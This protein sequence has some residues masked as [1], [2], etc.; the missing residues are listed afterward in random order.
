M[1]PHTP[2]CPAAGAT[3]AGAAHPV[4][5]HFEQGW[6]LLC[7]AILLFDVMSISQSQGLV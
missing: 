4:S 7:N 3:D 2:P 1:C 5:V 6:T